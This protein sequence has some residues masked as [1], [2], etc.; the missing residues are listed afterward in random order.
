MK[1]YLQKH[2]AIFPYHL[3]DYVCRVMR[4]S[5]CKNYCDMLLDVM[6]NEQCYESIP[7]FSAADALRLTGIGKMEFIDIVNKCSKLNRPVDEELLPMV[8]VDFVIQP[9]W[10]VCLTNFTSGKFKKLSAEEMAT[11]EKIYTEKKN[12][13]TLFDAEII[14]GLYRQGLVYFDVRVDPADCFKEKLV[15]P[16]LQK[17]Y[18]TMAFVNSSGEASS[19]ANI[20]SYPMRGSASLEEL[21]ANI[22]NCSKAG[23]WIGRNEFLDILTNCIFQRNKV[24]SQILPEVIMEILSRLPIKKIVQM[25]CI[26][27]SFLKLIESEEFAHFYDANPVI[28]IVACQSERNSEFRPNSICRRMYKIFQIDNSPE[29]RDHQSHY[30]L[31]NNYHLKDFLKMNGSVNEFFYPKQYH[32]T[33]ITTYGFG[34][35]KSGKY[36]VVLISQDHDLDNETILVSI[37]RSDDKIILVSITRSECQDHDLDDETTL[38]TITRSDDETTLVSITRSECQVYTL[39]TNL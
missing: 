14:K 21:F 2:R 39:G 5:P 36:K 1:D 38:V 16:I 10:V 26:N 4:V 20:T 30:R 32:R 35:I 13:F 22:P 15:D 9:W 23:A 29:L 24:T 6:R 33:K 12:S 28:C 34:K 31:V 11:I 8:P 37:T 19:S 25:K 7:V 3:A 17:S 27:K 18:G